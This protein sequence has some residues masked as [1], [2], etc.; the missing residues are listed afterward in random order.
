MTSVVGNKTWIPLEKWTRKKQRAKLVVVRNNRERNSPI[1]LADALPG[2]EQNF[3]TDIFHPFA[4]RHLFVLSTRLLKFARNPYPHLRFVLDPA[5]FEKRW[6]CTHFPQQFSRHCTTCPA[7]GKAYCGSWG[8]KMHLVGIA[9][10]CGS[11]SYCYDY[12][13][14]AMRIYNLL[15]RGYKSFLNSAPV[16]PLMMENSRGPLLIS[17]LAKVSF[18]QP[19]LESFLA[20]SPAT[21]AGKAH[22]T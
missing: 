10:G 19:K 8:E 21:T 12:C 9:D 14:Y 6:K 1:L 4:N 18:F 16:P 11:K 2:I 20:A 22:T 3:S 7:G 13:K 15:S 17:R 5:V